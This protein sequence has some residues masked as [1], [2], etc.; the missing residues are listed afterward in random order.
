SSSALRNEERASSPC[1]VNI[2]GGSLV[3][4]RA[5]G[6]GDA[7]AGG[8][9]APKARSGRQRFGAPAAPSQPAGPA[10]HPARHQTAEPL[11]RPVGRRAL[12]RRPPADRRAPRETRGGSIRQ[13]ET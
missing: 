8:P 3:G 7:R 9:K 13:T 4:L 1:S 6:P 12:G 5:A 2:G 11:R 10:A